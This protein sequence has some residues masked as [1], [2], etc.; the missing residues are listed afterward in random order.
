MST[1]VS[2]PIDHKYLRRLRV[3]SY[4]EGVSTLLLFGG[5]MPLKYAAGMPMAVSVVGTIHGFLF[6]LLVVMFILAINRVPMSAS[7]A[8]WG[9][10]AALFPF[11]PFV[12]DSRLAGLGR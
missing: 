6:V 10:V 8:R 1:P 5:A 12:F 2:N 3:V 7:L 4:V 9:M 11:G